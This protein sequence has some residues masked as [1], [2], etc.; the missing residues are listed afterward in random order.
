MPYI[1]LPKHKKREVH[2]SKRDNLN[3]KVYN[4]NFYR[5]LRLQHLM[6][7]PL[8]VLCLEKGIITSATITHHIKFLS[9][10]MSLEQKQDLNIDSNLM[11]LCESCHKIIHNSNSIYDKEKL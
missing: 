6:K 1:Y 4:T 5:E 9:S 11:S 8:C 7:S 10:E 2:S 3:H